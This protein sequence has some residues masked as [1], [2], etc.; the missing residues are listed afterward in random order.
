VGS[1]LENMNVFGKKK[2]GFIKTIEIIHGLDSIV[3]I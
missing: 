1:I 2:S 3:K